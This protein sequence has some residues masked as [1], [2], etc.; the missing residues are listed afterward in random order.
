[1]KFYWLYIVLCYTKSEKRDNMRVAIYGSGAMGTVLGAYISRAGYTIDLITRNNDHVIALNNDGAKII[2]DKGFTQTVK[3]IRSDNIKGKYD[4]ILLMTKQ[5]DNESVV[6]GLLPYM[7]PNSILCTCQNGL[8]EE[9][10]AKIIGNNRT[11]GCVISW[12]ASYISP[13]IVKITSKQK[14]KN[15]AFNIGKF[16]D[17]D[18]DKYKFLIHMLESMGVVKVEENLLGFRWSKL[19]INSAFSGLSV[20]TGSTFG[21]ISQN[22]ISRKIALK[23]IKEGIDVAKANNIEI[24]PIQGKNIGKLFGIKG[25]MGEWFSMMLLKFSMKNHKNIKSGMLRAIENNQKTDIDKINGVIS[26]YGKLSNTPTPFNDKIIELVKKI[27]MNEYK[28]GWSNLLHF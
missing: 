21:D 13:G 5:K 18:S 17:V 19:L 9:D 4:I 23:I 7:K 24:E 10:I 25:K 6:N 14:P 8:P 16:G 15:L 1:M 2:G 3:A 26:K 27:E 22:K 28:I 12:G 11:C 20:I